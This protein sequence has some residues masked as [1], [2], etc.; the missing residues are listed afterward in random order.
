MLN[1]LKFVF[2]LATLEARIEDLKARVKNSSSSSSGSRHH[3]SS[4]SMVV[5]PNADDH[6]SMV[7]NFESKLSKLEA[8]QATLKSKTKRKI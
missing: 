8:E 3:T 7:R 4:R 1:L 2:V 5:P 6:M